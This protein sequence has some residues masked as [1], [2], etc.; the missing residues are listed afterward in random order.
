ME[1][2]DNLGQNLNITS[3]G[4]TSE[5]EIEV[6]SRSTGEKLADA[7]RNFRLARKAKWMIENPNAAAVAILSMDNRR[8]AVL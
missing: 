6:R 4:G 1:I 8:D 7:I 2:D 3:D 5:R